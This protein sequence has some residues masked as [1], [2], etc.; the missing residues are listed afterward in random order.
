MQI[1]S[2]N[3]GQQV[4][5]NSNS[6]SI[7]GTSNDDLAKDCRVSVIVNGIK[8]YQPAKATGPNG[9]NDYSKWNFLL[10]SNYA[11]IKEGPECI[12]QHLIDL[13]SNLLT[14]IF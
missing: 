4:P 13:I 2:P 14:R 10:T 1:I 3:K 6:L 5:I 12:T 9:A 7:S 11:S 8:P